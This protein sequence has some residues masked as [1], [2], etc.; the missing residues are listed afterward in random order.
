MMPYVTRL[1]RGSFPLGVILVVLTCA[2]VFFG[3]QSGDEKRYAL[4]GDY[5]A[6]SVLPAV[7]LPAYE[8]YLRK[9]GEARQ[10]KQFEALKQSR[11][12]FPTLRLMQA[13]EVFMGRLRAGSIITDAHPQFDDWQRARRQFDAME[14]RL[15]TERFHFDTEHPTWLTAI[16]HQFMHGGT[17]HIVG[18]MIV[19]IL[20]GPAVEALIGTLPFLLLFV[21][22]GIGA[23]AG[24]WLAT[25]GAPGGLVGASGAIAAVMGAFAVLLGRRR[26]PFFY[27]VFV[28]FDVIRAPALL[29]LPIWLINEALQ[30]FWLG[31]AQVAYGAHFGGLLVGALLVL[32]LR[33]RALERLL[34]EGAED[35]AEA[36]AKPTAELAIHEARRLMS[37]QRFDEARRAYAR[38]A[39]QARGNAGVLRECLNVARLAPASAEYHAIVA[40]V[41]ALRGQDA[42]S[43][44]LVLESFR[45]YLQKARPLPQIAPETAV[46]L[47]ERF[48]QTRCLPELDRCARL[49][50]AS[51]PAHPGLDQILAL[52]VH[53]LRTAGDPLR[54]TELSKLKV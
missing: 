16:S 29:A 43:Q 42:A 44:A 49:L 15:F 34:P 22:G 38:A 45:D 17:G 7:E 23:A 37:S 9:Q 33:R 52:A 10:L 21:L 48:S 47:I 30:F 6:S 11:A 28:F 4:M 31:N 12:L 35:T 18:N 3:F 8:A 39:S 50:H 36:A 40:C 20:V 2:I 27:F 41:L 32:P 51:A 46:A 5:Y 53:A 13:D 54:A 26:I 1:T 25:Q 24:H 14:K 19:L